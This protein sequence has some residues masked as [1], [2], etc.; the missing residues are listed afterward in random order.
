MPHPPRTV[1]VDKRLSLQR[2]SCC[3]APSASYFNSIRTTYRLHQRS[4][5][6]ASNDDSDD[7]DDGTAVYEIGVTAHNLTCGRMIREWEGLGEKWNKAWAT[8]AKRRSEQVYRHRW[9]PGTAGWTL[10]QF[11]ADYV[12]LIDRIIS[13]FEDLG[14]IYQPRPSRHATA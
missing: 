9:I 2:S 12:K 11:G 7:L 1:P 4:K 14:A 6:E 13:L 8:V 3:S 10:Y 5:A